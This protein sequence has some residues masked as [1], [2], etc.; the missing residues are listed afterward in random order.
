MSGNSP[1]DPPSPGVPGQPPGQQPGQGYPPPSDAPPYGNTGWPQ[2]GQQPPGYQQPGYQQP[3]QQPPGWQQQPGWQQPPGYVPPGQ[4]QPPKKRRTGLWVA[5]G[6]GGVLLVAAIGLCVVGII[7]ALSND[8]VQ[9][10]I[11]ELA[12]DFSDGVPA[13]EPAT[14]EV[15]GVDDFDDYIV[16]TT[17]TNVSGEESHYLIDYE[18]TGPSGAFIGSDFGIVSNLADGATERDNTLGVIDDATPWQDVS[19]TVFATTRVPTG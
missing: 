12:I 19:C 11:S 18:L 9:E 6:I 8:Q 10:A 2:Q 14:C 15:T 7:A 3:G 5:L 13:A 16:F 4:G 1:F 17:V